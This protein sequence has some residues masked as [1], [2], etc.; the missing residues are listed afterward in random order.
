VK[1]G[2][3]VRGE[4]ARMI[5]LELRRMVR[6]RRT[7]IFTLIMPAVLVLLFGANSSYRTE[8]VGMVS[9]E[10]ATGWS[11]QLRLTPLKPVA[12]VRPPM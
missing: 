7:V 5:R 12:Y 10:R 9:V 3:A 6:N 11:R 2:A 8:R 4:V 1:L